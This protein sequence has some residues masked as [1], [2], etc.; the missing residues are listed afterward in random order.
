MWW[1]VKVVSFLNPQASHIAKYD[2]ISSADKGF[3]NVPL[4]PIEGGKR[5]A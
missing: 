3:E 1:Q 5:L 2:L 4:P